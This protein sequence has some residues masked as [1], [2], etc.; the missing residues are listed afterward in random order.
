MTCDMFKLNYN[1]TQKFHGIAW[2]SC[3]TGLNFSAS[4]VAFIQYSPSGV[5]SMV[6]RK[7]SLGMDC[8][9]PFHSAGV[10][11]FSCVPS[12]EFVCAP[13]SLLWNI[14]MKKWK[15]STEG[16]II[17]NPMKII[18]ILVADTVSWAMCPVHSI[19][20]C[21]NS[22]KLQST[23]HN[24][25]VEILQLLQYPNTSFFTIVKNYF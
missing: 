14:P 25:A 19:L 23:M 7:W 12:C 18:K 16:Y 5:A 6:Q 21:A 3:T 13:S 17:F 20:C 8:S 11:C 2:T 24:R 4:F 22:S 10:E 1:T 9:L 15:C